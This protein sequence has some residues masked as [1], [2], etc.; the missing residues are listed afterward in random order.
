M[1]KQTATVPFSK[2]PLPL[3]REYSSLASSQSQRGWMSPRRALASY[4]FPFVVATSVAMG[5][6]DPWA[7]SLAGETSV[8]LVEDKAREPKVVSLSEARRIA[9]EALA[10]AELDFA[11]YVQAEANAEVFWEE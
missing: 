3:G 11:A 6:I 9:L 5:G 4:V 7:G 8:R 10:R 1:S 2:E